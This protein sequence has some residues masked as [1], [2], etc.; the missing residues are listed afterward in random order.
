MTND[1]KKDF[2]K[3]L[4]GTYLTEADND[5]IV[6]EVT[7]TIR[8]ISGIC[9]MD[10]TDD[11]TQLLVTELLAH[12]CLLNFPPGIDDDLPRR[13]LRQDPAGQRFAQ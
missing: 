11:V 4:E 1:P 3:K 6:L 5:E 12:G 13:M 7:S 9:Y 10:I 2:V 8:T